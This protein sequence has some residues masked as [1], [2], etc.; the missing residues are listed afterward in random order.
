MRTTCIDISSVHL[1]IQ[2]HVEELI[3]EKSDLLIF[4]KDIKEQ[5]EV[6]TRWRHLI[7]SLLLC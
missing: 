4:T 6:A 7:H 5:S 1:G 2:L 3:S